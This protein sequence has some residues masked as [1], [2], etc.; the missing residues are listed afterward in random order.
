MRVVLAIMLSLVMTAATLSP[1]LA[2]TVRLTM[3][4]AGTSGT[5]YI[6]GAG[7]AEFIN[8]ESRT[9]RAIPSPSGGSV[10]NL[11]RVGRGQADLGI[12]YTGDMYNAWHGLQEFSEPMR[13]F[14]VLGPAQDIN[15]WQFYA[16]ADS[17]IRTLDDLIGK[18]FAPG[19]P[20]SGAAA[21]AELFLREAGIIDQLQLVYISWAETPGFV[22]DRVVDA[23]NR[24]GTHPLPML[25]E[26]D[27][28]HPVRV[29]DLGEAME[30]TRFLEKYPYFQEVVVQPGDYRG[31]DAPAR[32][33]G[34][35]TWW[36]V[37]EDLPED[38]VYELMKI[39]YSPEAAAWLDAV[40]PEHVHDSP[41]P[42]KGL[43]LPLH[44]GAIRYW[45]ERGVE[46]PAEA[47]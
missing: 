30:R 42:L 23:G 35:G 6:H 28:T 32:T 24:A 44:P 8:R 45:E 17:G 33:F 39:A 47:R 34:Q 25:Q 19:A 1:A 37:R 22:T 18:R 43:I 11:R 12:A 9:L 38:V 3:S 13:T 20:G 2:Q 27:V 21:N 31:Q 4:L 15:Y 5:F 46:I 7:L 36:V 16:L 14:R 29:L 10:E 40:Y 41:D 26:I